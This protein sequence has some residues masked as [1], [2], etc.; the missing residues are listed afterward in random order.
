MRAG[1]II[2]LTIWPISLKEA[3]DNR[4]DMTRKAWRGVYVGFTLVGICAAFL[5]Q[6]AIMF[7]THSKLAAA[8]AV[9]AASTSPSTR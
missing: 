1:K 8:A 3:K 5:A 4:F 2:G 7:L 9:G 6:P